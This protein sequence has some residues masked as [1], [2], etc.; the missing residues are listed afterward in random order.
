MISSV[1]SSLIP[2]LP[3]LAARKISTTIIK[4]IPA[5]SKTKIR[6]Y[7]GPDYI[8]RSLS[9]YPLSN[10]ELLPP[11]AGDPVAPPSPVS[12]MINKS[13]TEQNVDYAVNNF[14]G[15]FFGFQGYAKSTT[16]TSLTL[17][18]LFPGHPDP[19]V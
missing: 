3:V 16:V 18:F 19:S 1:P 17:Y 4:S 7:P 12:L 11:F 8:K 2:H 6:A 14:E 10:P 9:L 13:M 5:A 15:D